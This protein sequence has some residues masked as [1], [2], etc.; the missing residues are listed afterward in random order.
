MFFNSD[1]TNIRR[2]LGILLELLQRTMSLSM[3]TRPKAGT[4]ASHRSGCFEFST[5]VLCAT[6]LLVHIT[7]YPPYQADGIRWLGIYRLPRSADHPPDTTADRFTSA[8]CHTASTE[9]GLRRRQTR[10]CN[11]PRFGYAMLAV[12]RAAHAVGYHC[13]KAFADRRWNCTSIH[14]LPDVSPELKRGTREQAL[15]HAFSSAALL[16]EI[17]RYCAL[18]KIRSCSCGD[19]NNAYPVIDYPSEPG[20][21]IYEG[22]SEDGGQSASGAGN[23]QAVS[24]TD[25]QPTVSRFY[26]AGCSDNLQVAREYASAF[27]G[28]PNIRVVDLPPAETPSG[29]SESNEDRLKRVR[30]SFEP[31]DF[32]DADG[33]GE[34]E[35]EEGTVDTGDSPTQSQ[36]RTHHTIR[37]RRHLPYEWQYPYADDSTSQQSTPTNEHQQYQTYLYRPPVRQPNLSPSPISYL[38]GRWPRRLK[39]RGRRARSQIIRIMDRHNYLTGVVLMEANHRLNCK[40]HGV[41]GS[42]AQRV[43]FRQLRRID[44]A[45]MQKALKARYLAA[46]HVSVGANKQ[47]IA[48]TLTGSGFVDEVVKASELVFSEHSPDYCNKEPHRG[49]VGTHGRLCTLQDAGTANCL[50]MCCGRGYKNVTTLEI[51]DCNCRMGEGFKVK[52]DE[53]RREKVTQRCL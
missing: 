20:A 9:L 19:E 6:V 13:P 34:E 38:N 46:K 23:G 29:K 42:C 26:W 27:L 8:E 18:N 35:E 21:L 43:C 49:S 14:R 44:D 37:M 2:I 39:Q 1:K 4:F 3:A 41:S 11:H 32:E 40:C 53:C 7:G 48:K 12:L 22:G 17:G 10:F 5:F 51:A 24:M 50:N 45:V 16:F 25:G 33:D 31:L 15:V 52:C 30:R 36:V 28:F 47:L